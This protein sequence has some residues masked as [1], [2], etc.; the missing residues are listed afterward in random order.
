MTDVNRD[1]SLPP[2]MYIGEPVDVLLNLC[3]A[4]SISP[5][6]ELPS[7]TASTQW[8][9]VSLFMITRFVPMIRILRHAIA[10]A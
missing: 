8:E 5:L 2:E 3:A 1:N 7:T 4:C 9:P 10:P 6:F